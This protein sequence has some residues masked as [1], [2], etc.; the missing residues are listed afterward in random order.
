[1]HQIWEVFSYY[2]FKYFPVTIS[3]SSS[4]YSKW[5]AC[6]I[7]SNRSLKTV[8]CLTSFLLLFFRRDHFYLSSNWLMNFPVIFVLLLTYSVNFF[9]HTLYFLKFSL[10]SLV[11]ISLL[12]T[13]TFPFICVYL[14]LSHRTWDNVS[15]NSNKW[16]IS[17]LASIGSF[18]RR[19]SESLLVLCM[20]NNSGVYPG[21]VEY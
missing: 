5:H 2:F 11:S 19:I 6:L 17:R 21:H 20:L 9:F 13:S 14:P 7:W 16:V 3:F 8:V 1:M 12:W 15:D 18:P 10:G 4:G